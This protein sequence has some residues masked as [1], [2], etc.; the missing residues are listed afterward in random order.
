MKTTRMILGGIL[1][2]LILSTISV[3]FNPSSSDFAISNSN[4][5][6]LSDLSFVFNVQSIPSLDKLPFS[7]S[8]SVLLVIPQKPY[9]QNDLDAIYKFVANGGTMLLADDFGYGNSILSYLGVSVRFSQLRLIDPLFFYRDMYFPKILDVSSKLRDQDIN[10]L[11]FNYAT[12]L[13]QTQGI[14]IIASSSKASFLDYNGNGEY[15]QNEAQGPFAVA[16]SL[17][18]GKGVLELLSD[19]SIPINAAVELDDN[20]RFLQYEMSRN[21]ANTI[22]VDRSHLIQDP[23][24]TT[25]ELLAGIREVGSQTIFLLIFTIALFI[26]LSWEF[27]KKRG[28]T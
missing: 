3:W 24:E 19:S 28:N 5:N 20:L 7:N 22:M 25:K 9:S 6:G 15:D 14:E 27:I 4:W 23:Q 2:A 17:P 11:V 26:V 10:T 8:S 16:A 1:I 21:G 12:V 18:L 13:R